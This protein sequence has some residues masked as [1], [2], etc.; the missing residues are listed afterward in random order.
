M[1][2]CDSK[3]ENTVQTLLKLF[4][5]L[6]FRKIS[7]EIDY[8]YAT[9]YEVFKNNELKIAIQIKLKSYLYNAQCTQNA[10]RVYKAKNRLYTK[11][12]RVSIIILFLKQMAILSIKK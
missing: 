11:D 4:P 2:W 6:E 7:G 12:F 9:D 5:I 8:Q 3:R 1:E 10:Q